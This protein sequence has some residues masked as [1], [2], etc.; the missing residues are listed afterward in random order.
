MRQTLESAWA[1]TE[2]KVRSVWCPRCGAKVGAPCIAQ[3]QGSHHTTL[4]GNRVH[5][6]RAALRRKLAK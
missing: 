1:R 3:W 2:R 5:K 4:F 6:E